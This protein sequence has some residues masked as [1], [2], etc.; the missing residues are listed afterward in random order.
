MEWRELRVIRK[1]LAASGLAS[2][3]VDRKLRYYRKLLIESR[4]PGPC[5]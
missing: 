3:L 2:P 4:V 1:S 5:S